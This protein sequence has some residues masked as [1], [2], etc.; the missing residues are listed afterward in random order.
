VAVLR[1][2]GQERAA[3]A[4]ARARDLDAKPPRDF[5]RKAYRSYVDRLGPTILMNG[6]GQALATEHSGSEPA[7]KALYTS[8]QRWLCRKDGVYAEGEDALSAITQGGE[9]EYLRA[10]FEAL[11]WLEWHKKACRAIFPENDGAGE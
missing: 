3:N 4:L 5:S 1:A 11:A 7:H 6:L 10:Q 8:V 9:R 2:L